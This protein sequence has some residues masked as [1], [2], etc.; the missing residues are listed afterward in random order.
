MTIL[1][2]L[3][4]GDGIVRLGGSLLSIDVESISKLINMNHIDL[5]KNYSLNHKDINVTDAN[6]SSSYLK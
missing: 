2:Q 1:Y 6:F 5:L 4:L 3:F